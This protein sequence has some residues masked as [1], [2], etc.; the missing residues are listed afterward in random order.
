MME[1]RLA[2]LESDP[3]ANYDEL[4]SIYA[5]MLL[6][7]PQS[8]EKYGFRYLMKFPAMSA[9]YIEMNKGYLAEEPDSVKRRWHL[10][11]I[12]CFSLFSHNLVEY[13]KV[14]LENEKHD[15][16]ASFI[17][18]DFR[19]ID[20]LVT[21]EDSDCLTFVADN[22]LD[23]MVCKVLIAG[24]SDVVRQKFERCFPKPQVFLLRGRGPSPFIPDLNCALMMI[25]HYQGKA[26]EHKIFQTSITHELTHLDVRKYHKLPVDKSNAGA[27]KFFDEGLGVQNSYATLAD[28]ENYFTKFR[29]TAYLIRK[30]TDFSTRDIMDKWGDCITGICPIQTYDY[31]CA[32][33]NFL[34]AGFAPGTCMDFFIAWI[35]QTEVKFGIECFEL[36]YQVS[37]EEVDQAWVDSLDE[38]AANSIFTNKT[39]MEL[40]E[41]KSDTI[42]FSYTSEYE[43]WPE[44]NFFCL[45]ETGKLLKLESNDINQYRFQ[46]S[47]KLEVFMDDTE[48]CDVSR[49]KFFVLFQDKVEQII[50]VIK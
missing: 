38:F 39:K 47:G 36:Y 19:Q 4:N 41:I 27:F 6:D 22:R 26:Y 12:M 13:N 18:H 21:I 28:Y 10:K 7:E 15:S 29:N 44:Q 2:E 17:E 33:V 3:L 43:L 32:F 14:I 35:S 24:I 46:K 11:R 9:H 45:S 34:D 49:L 16:A 40:V 31:A 30:Y 8:L 42:V 50:P 23:P 48:R 20:K 37:F 1:N 5:G 25:G